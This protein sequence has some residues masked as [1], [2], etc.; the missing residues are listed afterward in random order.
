MATQKRN[1]GKKISSSAL[2]ALKEALST[3]YW[4]KS[5]LRSFLTHSLSDSSLVGRLNWQDYKRNIVCSLVDFLAKNEDVYQRE[6]LRL[7]HEVSQVQDFSHLQRLDDGQ[8]K[9][10]DAKAAVSALRKHVGALKSLF[11]GLF[12]IEKRF[13]CT[14]VFTKSGDGSLSIFCLLLPVVQSLKM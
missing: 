14:N 7:L 2:N 4:Y 6:L 11:N 5:D 1:F 10:E 13:Q 8:K 9:A 12:L 3:I